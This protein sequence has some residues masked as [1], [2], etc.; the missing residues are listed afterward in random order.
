MSTAVF[1][2]EKTLV[3][4]QQVHLQVQYFIYFYS[5]QKALQVLTKVYTIQAWSIAAAPQLA[6][7]PR[8]AAA[9]WPS[10]APRP[11]AAPWR[12]LLFGGRLFLAGATPWPAADLFLG[13]RQ[14][15]PW[16]LH[17]VHAGVKQHHHLVVVE[18][19]LPDPCRGGQHHHLVAVELLLHVPAGGGPAPPNCSSC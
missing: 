16:L 19:L 9:L 2:L 1:T 17:P 11:S 13:S 12:L 7:A 18:L 15:I 6:A 5:L 8:P 4:F 3:V 10:A 14:L